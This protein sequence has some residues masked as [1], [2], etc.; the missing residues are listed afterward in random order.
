MPQSN[1]TIPRYIDESSMMAHK[2]TSSKNECLWGEAFFT[3]HRLSIISDMSMPGM[4][5]DQSEDSETSCDDDYHLSSAKLFDTYHEQS[6]RAASTLLTQVNRTYARENHQ[7]P[8]FPLA[9]PRRSSRRNS[10]VL[11]SIKSSSSIDVRPTGR[12]YGT[13]PLCNDA[14][15]LASSPRHSTPET[16]SCP[17]YNTEPRAFSHRS[18]PVPSSIPLTIE[19]P[20]TSSPNHIEAVHHEQSYFEY[21]DDEDGAEGLTGKAMKRLH[22]RSLSG[23]KDIKGG[24]LRRFFRSKKL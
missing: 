18:C 17:R 16:S 15:Q 12:S 13:W 22:I 11:Q 10:N 3:D 9:N 8:S 1:P 19:S 21:S 2:H 4:V 6:I 7:Y 24:S 5:E 20:G 14:N 23:T